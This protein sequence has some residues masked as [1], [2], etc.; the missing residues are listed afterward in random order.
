[1]GLKPSGLVARLALAVVLVT[2][3][4]IVPVL[5]LACDDASN[6]DDTSHAHASPAVVPEASRVVSGGPAVGT[7]GREPPGR[8]LRVSRLPLVPPRA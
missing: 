5:E 7:A 6:A 3:L 2:L 1:M 8:A 4:A